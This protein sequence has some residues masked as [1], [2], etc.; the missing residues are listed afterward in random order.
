ML[1]YYP[2]LPTQWDPT[3]AEDKVSLSCDV[4][5]CGKGMWLPYQCIASVDP[6]ANRN[7][8]IRQVKDAD[9]GIYGD[10]P[11]RARTL[12]PNHQ[13]EYEAYQRGLDRLKWEQGRAHDHDERRWYDDKIRHYQQ[14]ARATWATKPRENYYAPQLVDR[15]LP[16]LPLF[17]CMTCTREDPHTHTK[18]ELLS[19][20]QA[21]AM[22]E[23]AR[24]RQTVAA[25]SLAG[26]IA[27]QM[28]PSPKPSL[29]RWQGL[30]R[31]HHCNRPADPHPGYVSGVAALSA[32]LH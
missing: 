27:G 10:Q 1:K 28:P 23:E 15:L 3:G 25:S 5:S 20:S 24:R 16:K 2:N 12:C 13:H 19:S 22:R 32:I 8:I 21:E 18:A 7:A 26:V 11:E 31:P 4:A 29:P 30:A 17:S 6:N 14:I 9:W